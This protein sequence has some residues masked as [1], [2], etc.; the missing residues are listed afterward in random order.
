MASSLGKTS[1][2]WL[3]RAA[4][5]N[6]PVLQS[7]TWIWEVNTD[8]ATNKYRYKYNIYYPSHLREEPVGIVFYKKWVHQFF[9]HARVGDPYLGPVHKE[10]TEY[11]VTN[12][13][14]IT[15]EEPEDQLTLQIHQLLVIID[16]EQPESLERTREPWAPDVTPTI[17]PATY[18]TQQTQPTLAKRNTPCHALQDF[19]L[20]D[21]LPHQ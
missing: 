18:T 19:Y 3:D 11:K 1:H 21:A 9:Y 10:A 13:S 4:L 14:A 8:N 12:N 6:L 15:D 16:K 7:D 2:H 5:H 17:A 20:T